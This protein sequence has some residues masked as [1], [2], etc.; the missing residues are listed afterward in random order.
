M[1]KYAKILYEKSGG[2]YPFTLFKIN[3]TKGVE[4]KKAKI[5]ITGIIMV[6]A[7]AFMSACSCAETEF[8]PVYETGISIRCT[9]ESVTSSRDDESG[10]LIIE[11]YKGERFTIEYTLTPAS[12]TTTQVDWEFS[13][14]SGILSTSTFSYSKGA[15][16]SISFGARSVGETTITFKTKTTGKIAKAKVIVSKEKARIPQLD[17]PSIFDFDIDSG[18]VGWNNVT[19]VWLSNTLQDAEAFVGTGV[20]KVAK[21]LT[22]YSV[23]IWEMEYNDSGVPNVIESTKKEVAVSTNKIT[24]PEGGFVVGKTYKVKVKAVGDS[25]NAFTSADSTEFMFHQVEPVNDLGVDNGAISFTAPKFSQRCEVYY[26]DK[27]SKTKVGSS[28]NLPISKLGGE[29]YRGEN[30]IKCATFFGELEQYNVS[31]VAM[32]K[33]FDK[34]KNYYTENGVRYYQSPRSNSFIFRKLSTPTITLENVIGNATVGGIVFSDVNIKSVLRLDGKNVGVT[35]ADEVK[36]Q[37]FVSPKEIS[38]DQLVKIP[39]TQKGDYTFGDGTVVSVMTTS[40][41]TAEILGGNIVYA[42]LVG[43]AERTIAGKFVNFFYTKLGK[44]YNSSTGEAGTSSD[45][46]THSISNNIISVN[47]PNGIGGV[48]FYFVNASSPSLSKVVFSE[49]ALCNISEAGLSAGTYGIYA[50]LVGQFGET[51]RTLTS[52]AVSINPL[53][54]CQ[55]LENVSSTNIA[56]DGT[57][58]FAP[59]SSTIGGTSTQIKNYTIKLTKDGNTQSVALKDSTSVEDYEITLTKVDG[60]YTFNIFDVAKVL[61]AKV[62]S[63]DVD[64][65]EQSEVDAYLQSG[66]V[67]SYVIVSDK[68][69][70]ADQSANGNAVISSKGSSSVFFGRRAGISSADLKGSTRLEFGKV[71]EKYVVILKTA[72]GDIVSEETTGSVNGGVVTIDLTTL[73]CKG[74]TQKLI[75]YIANETTIVLDVYVVG[76][77]SGVGVS[78]ILNSVKARFTFNQSSV[79]ENLA[80]SPSGELGWQSTSNVSGISYVVNFYVGEEKKE[81]KTVAYSTGTQ[82]GDKREYK[83]NIL[84]VI[85][86][87]EGQVVAIDVLESHPSYFA[88]H[89]SEKMYVTMLNTVNVNRIASSTAPSFEWTEI[90]RA[91][92]YLI[93]CNQAVFE[94]EGE[95]TNSLILTGRSYTMP[96]EPEIGEYTFTVVAQGTN[97]TTSGYSSENPY[98]LSSLA[99]KSG[100]NNPSTNVSVI[101]GKVSASVSSD[102]EGIK[103]SYSDGISYAI[104]YKLASALDYGDAVSDEKI[105]TLSGERYLSFAEM[106]AGEYNIKVDTSVDYVSSGIWLKDNSNQ[107]SITKLSELENISTTDGMASFTYQSEKNVSFRF[108]KDGKVVSSLGN[109]YTI[110]NVAGYDYNVDFYGLPSGQFGLTAKVMSE[111]CINSNLSQVKNL[112]KI[113]DVVDMDMTDEKLQWSYVEGA[114]MFEIVVDDGSTIKKLGVAKNGDNFTCTII[115]N[116]DG[117]EQ[118][119]IT[120][121]FVYNITSQ[122]FEYTPAFGL[123]AGKHTFKIRALTETNDYLNGNR[124]SIEVVKLATASGDL[125]SVSENGLLAYGQYETLD[126]FEPNSV[127]IVINKYIPR[128]SGE[129]ET[130]EGTE[131]VEAESEGG[132]ASYDIDTSVETI[133]VTIPFAEYL[134][135]TLDGGVYEID[136]RKYT[137]YTEVGT[138]GTIITFIGNGK[139][140]MSSAESAV[141]YFT[142]NPSVGAIK[143]KE[144]SL[145]FMSP[146]EGGKYLVQ[147]KNSVGELAVTFAYESTDA[148][149]ILPSTISEGDGISNLTVYEKEDAETFTYI[150]GQMYTIS[151]VTLKQNMLC[152]EISSEF[153]FKKLIAPT[154]LNMQLYDEA[155]NGVK[156]PVLLWTNQNKDRTGYDLELVYFTESGEPSE[157]M[158]KFESASSQYYPLSNDIEVGKYNIRMRALGTT[159]AESGFGL[160]TSDYSEVTND[161][162]VEY[163]ENNTVPAVSNGKLTWSVLPSAI[164]YRIEISDGVNK[165]TIYKDGSDIDFNSSAYSSKISTLS[166]GYWDISVTAITNPQLAMISS[167]ATSIFE[168]KAYRPSM[169]GTYKVKNGKLSWTISTTE[170]IKYLAGVKIETPSEGGAESEPQS[171]AETNGSKA[172]IDY[173]SFYNYVR[174]MALNGSS[175]ITTFDGIYTEHLYKVRL[176]MNGVETI[177]TPDEVSLLD[178]SGE[179]VTDGS[180]AVKIE[181]LYD[182][183]I[184]NNYDAVSGEVSNNIT[185][186]AGIEYTAGYYD[187]SICAVG[188]Q[189]VLN[190]IESGTLKT[191][192]LTT[193]K[194]WYNKTLVEEGEEEI[195]DIDMGEGDGEGVEDDTTNE[196]T[197]TVNDIS[198]GKALWELSVIANQNFTGENDKFTY[199]KDYYL[200]A[201]TSGDESVAYADVSV[202]DLDGE[203]KDPNVGDGYKYSK[204]VKEMFYN[205]TTRVLPDSVYRLFI[206]A[207]GTKD[208]TP[209]TDGV[210]KVYLLNSNSYMFSDTMTILKTCETKTIDGQFTWTPNQ[211]SIT[212]LVKIYGPL[213]KAENIES[214]NQDWAED[215]N[216][217]L[218]LAKIKYAESM[219]KD[220]SV[221]EDLGL[222]EAQLLETKNYV[223][224]H[225]TE[226][227]EMVHEINSG[228]NGEE[229]TGTITISDNLN[230]AEGGYAIYE[231][232]IGNGRGIV[233]SPMSE[234]VYSYKLGKTSAKNSQSGMDY[235]LGTTD[236]DAGKFVWKEVPFANAYIVVIKKISV[237]ADANANT[238][239]CGENSYLVD[240]CVFDMPDDPTLNEN[241]YKYSIEIIATRRDAVSG[242]DGGAV[243]YKT[244]ENFFNSDTVKTHKVED[245]ENRIWSGSYLRLDIPTEIIVSADSKVSWNNGSNDTTGIINRYEI[246]YQWE[247]NAS[248]V[249]TSQNATTSLHSGILGTTYI[250]VKAVPTYDKG[251]L[252]SSYSSPL[253]I[254]KIADP[255]PA[256]EDGVFGWGTEKD[257]EAKQS[258][259]LPEL[260]I[261][262]IDVSI[263]STSILT[264]NYFTEVTVDNFGLYNSSDDT[265]KFGVGKHHIAIKYMGTAGSSDSHEGERFYLAS[266]TKDF[267]I[268]KLNTPNLQNYVNTS[269]SQDSKIYWALQD[270]A[271]GYKLKFFVKTSEGYDEYIYMI[272]KDENSSARVEI[273]YPNRTDF[274]IVSQLSW[275]SNEYFSVDSQSIV[276]NMSTLI[277]KLENSGAEIIAFV[278]A[279]GSKSTKVGTNENPA[280][281]SSSYSAKLEI[282]VPSAPVDAEYDSATG[283]LTWS[284][285]N[286]EHI[287]SSFNII[288]TATYKL[289]NLTTEEK[290][291][292]LKSAHYYTELSGTTPNFSQNL[293]NNTGFDREY[294]DD[295]EVEQRVISYNYGSSRN[296]T[297]YVKDTILLVSREGQPT[298]TRY[299]LK[300]VAEGYNFT[301]TTTAYESI[302]SDKGSYKSQVYTPTTSSTV[303]AV[304]GLF[305]GGNGTKNIPYKVAN[306]NHLDSIR[307]YSSSNF[308]L[309]NDIKIESSQS[310]ASYNYNWAMIDEFTG[311]IDGNDNFIYNLKPQPKAV[312]NTTYMSFIIDNRGTIKN[313]K[314]QVDIE[315]ENNS[316]IVEY[317]ISGVAI[318]N[319]GTLNGVQVAPYLVDSSNNKVTEGNSVDY[320]K[321]LIAQ[322]V[323]NVRSQN[324]V[325]VGG[326]VATNKGSIE[327]SVVKA[328]ISCLTYGDTGSTCFASAGGIVGKTEGNASIKNCSFGAVTVM[329]TKTEELYVGQI[330]ANYVAGIVVSTTNGASSEKS[331]VTIEKCY[332]DKNV[333]LTVTDA[334]GGGSNYKSGMLGAI[335]C[336]A[337]TDVTISMC[338]SLA[339]VIVEHNS[340]TAGESASQ[341]LVAGI[342]SAKVGDATITIDKCYVEVNCTFTKH[343]KLS[344][345]A[346]SRPGIGSV[347]N[348]YYIIG[349]CSVTAGSGTVKNDLDASSGSLLEGTASGEAGSGTATALGNLKTNMGN[350]G[351]DVSGDYPRF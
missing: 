135:S 24:M 326:L 61:L 147:I 18:V 22:G 153:G 57:I 281:V 220:D 162:K 349:D 45:I 107:V 315:Y 309:S 275:A 98:I 285:A 340:S 110:T 336:S 78:G 335:M 176:K 338:Y 266:S 131:G 128:T 300:A 130:E 291:A 114:T 21:G 230:F 124:T 319:Y 343:S 249:E 121:T 201:I 348:S 318:N 10:N 96:S 188:G 126:G 293:T 90:N 167:V 5:F 72:S 168:T 282:Y 3:L 161:C 29:S 350:L 263:A 204:D 73:N 248:Y 150:A 27:A 165:V 44:V 265:A 133:E 234:V 225:A 101:N 65:V 288:L 154:A 69:D 23:S 12:V 238:E 47:N 136:I 97:T 155:G 11:C 257:K 40:D 100:D 116:V 144:G 191:Y 287:S 306:Y 224:E 8:T 307:Y 190:G 280:I 35:S 310:G 277:N 271:S 304:M 344:I 31:V 4:M 210:D 337:N 347:T 87:Y 81:A 312:N 270:S 279:I 1:T 68:N 170:I 207:M 231:Q 34:D 341:I 140:V 169:L 189:S 202:G 301:L 138:Y 232:E 255:E 160:L 196:P 268:S 51:A 233:D 179:V 127:K 174:D 139:R 332:V 137:G 333:E 53:Y 218:M 120:E 2:D 142:K 298:P 52:E 152:S 284:L 299:K 311:V 252:R 56:S 62:E 205:E 185:N 274:E 171:I 317:A 303:N 328:N 295:A 178:A 159:T 290:N 36:Y 246:S 49:N 294:L 258:V 89:S 216:T 278:Q 77:P 346:I 151:I 92:E 177:D 175:E 217:Q 272:Y 43:N 194:S 289:T 229:R 113:V 250:R 46:A 25:R 63:G 192:K 283:E 213:Y 269:S 334:S 215:S 67:F 163:I 331:T 41:S 17:A 19:K 256:V 106:D 244:S 119:S 95:K 197:Y 37:Y 157:S 180:R 203:S 227:L 134:A 108:Y 187:I 79:P 123:D 75:E 342:V 109:N 228:A 325:I 26:S 173:S 118:S 86:K 122:K 243:T 273:K 102:G 211:N 276:F 50:R 183:S 42:R 198:N 200:T 292:W 112:I 322:I 71:A 80:M 74:S 48:E 141:S 286:Q 199:H 54:T 251:Y 267:Y 84:E 308:V 222:S 93:T 143:T 88:S 240:S 132:E 182:V 64:T 253:E 345:V 208:S 129:G 146:V 321:S 117:E 166:G 91:S 226:L 209:A 158:W 83:L 115:E 38:N 193:P 206:Q 59:V 302:S 6:L 316:D 32:P 16:E 94:G 55:I 149:I 184:E 15:V 156:T 323:A 262:D 313:T 103:W 104:Y 247:G 259:T 99:T 305:A 58:T 111:G 296:Y 60:N 223:K 181:Y 7:S 82:V 260:K 245:V 186:S 14:N 339:N 70:D 33:E 172:V 329:N 125:I 297:L 13:D 327:N 235:W 195:P 9:T 219:Q 66:S 351:Y 239:M 324:G 314:F 28:S 105:E 20:D 330:K 221:F 212:S 164:T 264:Y 214:A 145:S 261:D 85:S 236:S 30:S 76:S 241:G 320:E 148:E 39:A 237:N 254:T 242:A